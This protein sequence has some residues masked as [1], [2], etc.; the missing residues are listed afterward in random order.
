MTENT[1]VTVQRT[2]DAPAQAVFDVLSN[3]ARHA[4]IDGSGFIV[5][6]EKTDRIT[7]NGQVFRM[8][9]QGDHMGGEYQ[10][11]NHV[12]GYDKNHLLAWKTAPADTDP[13]GWQWSWQL[14]PQGSESTDVQLTYDW[15][16]V[17]DQ[18]LLDKVGFP[19]VSQQQLENSLSNLASAVSG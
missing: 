2:I 9:M 11:D 13:P 15:S 3:P 5:S 16:Q 17:T 14:A 4:E 10:T 19:L 8:N 1:N 6:D 7:E 18:K 12:V